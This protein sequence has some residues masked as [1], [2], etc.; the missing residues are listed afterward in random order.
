MITAG[1]RTVRRGP[2]PRL[3]P[4]ALLAMA[5]CLTGAAAT[6]A[7]PDDVNGKLEAMMARIQAEPAPGRRV[8]TAQALD[9]YVRDLDPAQRR[10]IRSE[11]LDDI[12]DLLNSPV[13]GVEAAAAT[14]LGRIGSTAAPVLPLLR[15]ARDQLMARHNTGKGRKSRSLA[16]IQAAIARIADSPGQGRTADG[17]A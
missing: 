13:D 8:R 9:A 17:P 4:F 7:A 10:S 2:P 16:A 1:A 5:L 11:T 6:G 3:R 12:A 15:L 14:A